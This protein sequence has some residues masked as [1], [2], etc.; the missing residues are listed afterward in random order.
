MLFN[1]QAFILLFLPIVAL[2]YYHAA[3]RRDLRRWLLIAASLFFYAYWDWR[4]LPLLA[5]SVIVN[6]LLS[7]LISGRA[8]RAVLLGVDLNLGLLGLFK[9]LDF[10]LG[11]VAPLTGLHAEPFNIVLPL[12]ISFFTFQQISYLVDRGSG[13]APIYS[14]RDYALYVTFFPQL[15]AGPI[16]RHDE[17]IGQFAAD[18]CRPGLD[19]RL[20]KGL[21]LF[22]IGLVKK[23]AI[24]DGLALIADPLF[25][26]A[27]TE[28]IGFVEA[29]TA[30]LAFAMQ[31][32][33][34]FSAYSDM[35]IGL[36][37]I[38]GF[39]LPLNFASPYKAASII[40]FWRR[41]HMTLS[42]FLRDYLY[43]PLGGNRY[44][45]G[46]R[47]LAV[48]ATMLLGGLWHGAAWTFVAWGAIHG[49]ALAVNQQWRRLGFRLPALLG[50]LMTFMVAVLAFVLFRA[51]GF[52]EGWN[53][54]WPALGG[55]GL[56]LAVGRVAD[57]DSDALWRLPLA[58]LVVLAAPPSQRL[59]E[60]RLL[61]APLPAAALG[62]TLAAVAV[63]LGGPGSAE[64]I[65]FQF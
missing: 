47:I 7:H 53:V 1:S 13:R 9:Y 56:D 22:V 18:P 16:V 36:G 62:A 32:Y 24:A 48:T 28:P 35:A 43:I 31:I 29:W 64:F 33:F 42:R 8:D 14:F 34:D 25:A 52:G 41:W 40:D 65:Y 2:L 50:W 12:G 57:I 21:A 26:A 38:F 15:I 46:R 27:G 10:L 3:N 19:E 11:S 5:G 44:G 45:Q 55:N 30:A 61:P 58:L 39:A 51:E 63:V 17:I 60:H 4:F 59:I 37:L 23:V 49:T 20:S 6:W 54:L